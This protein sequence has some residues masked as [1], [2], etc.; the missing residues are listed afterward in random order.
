MTYHQPSRAPESCRQPLCGYL[1]QRSVGAEP[2][3]RCLHNIPMHGPDCAWHRT[4][5]QIALI[6]A[7]ENDMAA[8]VVRIHP[9]RSK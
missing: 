6:N 4:P 3:D 1:E 5:E 9:R 7:R 8:K 2:H